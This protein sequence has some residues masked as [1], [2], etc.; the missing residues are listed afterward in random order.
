MEVY[1]TH[2]SCIKPENTISDEILNSRSA[3]KLLCANCRMPLILQGHFVPIDLLE[4]DR[5]GITFKAKDLDFP[6]TTLVIKLLHPQNCSGKILSPQ[7]LRRI[8]EMF[9]REA[10][11]LDKLNH[12]RIPRLLAF[13]T[14]KIEE[15]TGYREKFFYLVQDYIEGQDLAKELDE[16]LKQNKKFSEDEVISI[17]NEIMNILQIYL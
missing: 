4:S 3:T 11:I 8:E 13:F 15:E 10:T 14:L 17:L 5:F 12:S 9:V 1:C 16:K 6:S 7:T 2:P